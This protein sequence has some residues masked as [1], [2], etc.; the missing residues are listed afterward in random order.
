MATM[1]ENSGNSFFNVIMIMAELTSVFIEKSINKFLNL[2]ANLRRRI[3]SLFKEVV[4]W[5]Y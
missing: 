2:R 1:N 4:C 3:V 5:V